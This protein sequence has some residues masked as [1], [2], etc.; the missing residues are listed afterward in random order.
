MYLLPGNHILSP[1]SYQHLLFRKQP[2]EEFQVVPPVVA[3]GEVHEPRPRFLHPGPVENG[4]LAAVHGDHE[5]G[6][7]RG[8]LFLFHEPDVGLAL[9]R[10]AFDGKNP[11]HLP[12]GALPVYVRGKVPAGVYE[13]GRYPQGHSV[14]HFPFLLQ[15]VV[16]FLPD[17][18]RVG[19]PGDD[20][21]LD[22]PA[23]FVPVPAYDLVFQPVILGVHAHGHDQHPRGNLGVVVFPPPVELL[24]FAVAL[25]QLPALPQHCVVENLQ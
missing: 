3:Y 19:P 2:P 10:L 23:L 13:G 5:P 12:P 6:P 17:P 1:P 7:L 20:S 15:Q 24:G 9:A 18:R 4:L 22:A 11:P 8:V 16:D 21:P 25:P 14:G